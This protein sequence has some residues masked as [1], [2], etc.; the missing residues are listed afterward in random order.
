LKRLDVK[1]GQDLD[2]M[3]LQQGYETGIN[4]TTGDLLK[5]SKTAFQNLSYNPC[6]QETLFVQ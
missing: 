5:L 1:F 2:K 4:T 3:T 6:N